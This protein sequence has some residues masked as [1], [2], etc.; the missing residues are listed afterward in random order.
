M[1]GRMQTRYVSESAVTHHRPFFHRCPHLVDQFAG[2]GRGVLPSEEHEEAGLVAVLTSASLRQRHDAARG[3]G[4]DANRLELRPRVRGRYVIQNRRGF[5]QQAPVILPGHRREVVN[6][7]PVVVED[8]EAGVLE[9]EGQLWVVVLKTAELHTGRRLDDGLGGAAQENLHLLTVPRAKLLTGHHA[10]DVF[11]VSEEHAA[12]DGS[13]NN[14]A[15]DAVIDGDRRRVVQHVD[16]A[17]LALLDD[18]LLPVEF[19][20]Q[21]A[22][23]RIFESGQHVV[24]GI[25]LGG[26]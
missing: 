15:V 7:A 16:V 13:E 22:H 3:L 4:G 5:W 17:V 26:N 20:G 10:L 24:F 18:K 11:A 19:A 8:A 2:V 21:S 9:V 1:E 23:G 12:L 14:A 6:V 25:N